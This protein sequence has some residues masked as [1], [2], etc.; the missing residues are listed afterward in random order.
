LSPAVPL[1]AES[2]PEC[3]KALMDAVKKYGAY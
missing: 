3:V 2:K 1:A